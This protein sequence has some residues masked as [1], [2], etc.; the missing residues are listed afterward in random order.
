[1]G[2]LAPAAPAV[3]PMLLGAGVG[4]ALNKGNPLQGAMLGALGGSVLGPMAS[5]LSGPGA[6]AAAA[7]LAPEAASYGAAGALTGAGWT[8]AQ[9]A[10]MAEQ[11]G[12]FGTAGLTHALGSSGVNP[13][14]G[15][16]ASLATMGPQ[17]IIQGMSGKDML[18]GGL[19]MAANPMITGEQQQAPI[20][21]VQAPMAA[22]APPRMA[23]APAP[24]VRK[25][26][27][28]MPMQ[29][30]RTVWDEEIM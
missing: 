16:A 3:M 11:A 14:I 29:K 22:P 20:A 23:Q 21:P 8:P 9:A 24:P 10:M 15:K 25:F 26:I 4:A 5:S 7:G 17:G 1:M 13:I 18:M 19:K 6:A 12:S 28:G 30:K 27:T 2:F